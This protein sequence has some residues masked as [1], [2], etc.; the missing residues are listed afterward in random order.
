MG[1][2]FSLGDVIIMGIGATVQFVV[3]V[4]TMSSIR[5]LKTSLATQDDLLKAVSDLKDAVLQTNSV[6]ASLIIKIQG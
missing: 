2:I 4:Y 3:V 1:G 5:S 6:L